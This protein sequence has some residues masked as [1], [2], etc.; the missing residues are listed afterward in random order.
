A[1]GTQLNYERNIDVQD[2]DM[3]W[4]VAALVDAV[5]RWQRRAWVDSA[6]VSAGPLRGWLRSNDGEGDSGA[7]ASRTVRPDAA[8]VRL[9]DST[10]D[11]KAKPGAGPLALAR[12]PIAFEQVREMF[13]RNASARVGD[14]EAHLALVDGHFEAY[15]ALVG[16][17]D[18]VSQQVREDLQDSTAIAVDECPS[19]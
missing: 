2:G 16:E 18:C 12:L 1:T 4:D 11:V 3:F 13:R 7:L 5:S 14:G 10:S 19:C 8:A 15:G 6:G 9:D 17:L